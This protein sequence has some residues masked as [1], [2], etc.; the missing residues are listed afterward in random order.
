MRN[1]HRIRSPLFFYLQTLAASVLS[2]GLQ[3]DEQEMTVMASVHPNQQ[4][5]VTFTL[6]LVRK[7]IDIKF[8]LEMRSPSLRTGRTAILYRFRIPLAQM[9]KIIEVVD[10]NC[11]AL[12]IPLDTPPSFY[13][14]TDDIE[15]THDQSVARWIEW[16]TWFRQTDITENAEALSVAPVALP[17]DHV[18]I[19]IGKTFW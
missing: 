7:E 13:R 18:S 15:A 19:E 12:V 1:F 11:R 10:G 3:K 16:F 6:D 2:F 5:P 9:T 14:Q 4:R 8:W 17:K